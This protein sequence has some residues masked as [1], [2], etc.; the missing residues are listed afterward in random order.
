M[1]V[2]RVPLPVKLRLIVCTALFGRTETYITAFSSQLRGCPT[3]PA[4]ACAQYVLSRLNVREDNGQKQKPGERDG[5]GSEH[6]RWH[7]TPHWMRG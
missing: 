1:H 7:G 2:S 6:T 3:W 4:Q 5:V